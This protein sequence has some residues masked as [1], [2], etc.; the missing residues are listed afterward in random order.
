MTEAVLKAM[1]GSSA[2]TRSL[3]VCSPLRRAMST[4]LMGFWDRLEDNPEEKILLLPSLLEVSFNPDT[5]CITP[6]HT[7]PVPSWIESAWEDVDMKAAYSDRIDVSQYTGNKPVSSNGQKRLRAFL[8]W[9]FSEDNDLYDTIIVAGGHSLWTRFF[10]REFLP[11]GADHTGA[12]NK[13]VNAGVCAMTVEM[14]EEFFG[15]NITYNIVPDSI[16][17]IYGGFKGTKSSKA[18]APS[19]GDGDKK[20]T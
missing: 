13:L 8:D 10:F 11:E 4:A 9:V 15:E 19:G 1:R 20:A 7:Q 14:R 17:T 18:K 5:L 3:L 12:N 16:R 2:D 6:A